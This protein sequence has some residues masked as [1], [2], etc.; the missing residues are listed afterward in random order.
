MAKERRDFTAMN[1]LKNKNGSAVV[2]PESVK[3]KWKKYMEPLMNVENTRDAEVIE[4]P[5][6]CTTELEVENA[7]NAMKFCK[8]SDLTNVRYQVKCCLRQSVREKNYWYFDYYK[9]IFL[10]RQKNYWQFDYN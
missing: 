10:I 2:E 5:I 3:K 7:L 8:A 9:Q 4:R 1:C 6:E